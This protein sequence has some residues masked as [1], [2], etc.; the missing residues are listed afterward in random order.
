MLG[1]ASKLRRRIC[2]SPRQFERP[3]VWDVRPRICIPSL[4][5]NPQAERIKRRRGAFGVRPGSA[6]GSSWVNI[7][8]SKREV[9]VGNN[10]R[11][12]KASGE[13]RPPCLRL[14][15]F[16]RFNDGNT[17]SAFHISNSTNEKVTSLS[18]RGKSHVRVSYPILQAGLILKRENRSMFPSCGHP[19]WGGACRGRRPWIEGL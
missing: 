16:V 13:S 12:E 4:R 3:P 1:L 2:C 5:A 11:Q 15:P 8:K 14:V 7:V 9:R 17:V 6:G 19:H 18:R 10:L